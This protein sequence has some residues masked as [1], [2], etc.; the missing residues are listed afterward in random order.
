[1]IFTTDN[2]RGE[3]PAEIAR[4]LASGLPAGRSCRIELDRRRAIALAIQASS[5]VDLVVLAGR[6]H[7]AGEAADDPHGGASDA[8]LARIALAE[9]QTAAAPA[10]HAVR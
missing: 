5:E 8:D 6:G 4:H 3:D 9:R 10:T 7:E 1:M 2:P